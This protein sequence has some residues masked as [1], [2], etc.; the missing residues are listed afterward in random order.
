MR[1]SPGPAPRLTATR[2]ALIRAPASARTAAAAT[3]GR[4]S[5]LPRSAISKS[6]GTRAGV[7]A[8]LFKTN[9]HNGILGSFAI[10]KNGDT[11]ANPVTI[12]KIKGGKSVPFKVIVPPVSLVKSA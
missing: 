8:L 2:W 7:T 12:Y 3:S 10:N 1:S 9:V 4:S 6:D 11:N 5:G